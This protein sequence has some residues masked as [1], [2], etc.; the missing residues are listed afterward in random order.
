MQVLKISTILSIFIQIDDFQVLARVSL[1]VQWET[2]ESMKLQVVLASVSMETPA[3]AP[4]PA[5]A[6]APVPFSTPA[7]RQPVPAPF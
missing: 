1:F 5:L 4:L 2:L 6:T 3:K 7:L